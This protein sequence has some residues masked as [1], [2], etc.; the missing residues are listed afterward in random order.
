VVK[1]TKNPAQLTE[2]D[3]DIIDRAILGLGAGYSTLMGIYNTPQKLAE[4]MISFVR[5]KK[6]RSATYLCLNARNIRSDRLPSPNE[7]NKDLAKVML[8]ESDSPVDYLYPCDMTGVT[9]LLELLGT[10]QNIQ[11]KK[12]IKN[13]GKKDKR[14][15]PRDSGKTHENIGGRPSIVKTTD[16]V[17]KLQKLMSNPKACG[18][19]RKTLLDSNLIFNYEK[20]ILKALY[21]AAKKDKTIVKELFRMI[22]SNEFIKSSEF[23]TFLEKFLSTEESQLETMASEGAR[24]SIENQRFDGHLFVGALLRL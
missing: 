22:M 7:L 12:E 5:S 10:H 17:K 14:G 16:M 3:G 18:R 9:K 6:L 15:R 21:Y 4:K 19:I 20:F 11:G 2:E 1:K 23:K 13:L 8:D 24:I